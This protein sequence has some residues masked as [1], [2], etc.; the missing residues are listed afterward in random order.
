MLLFLRRALIF[1]GKHVFMPKL[2]A[3]AHVVATS[4]M[5]PC[6]YDS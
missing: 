2:S 4:C 1:S 3:A 6:K 5:D